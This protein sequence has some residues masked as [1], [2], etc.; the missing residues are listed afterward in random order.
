MLW[1][2]KLS[3]RLYILTL[4]ETKPYL[5][6][7]NLAI[8]VLALSLFAACNNDKKDKNTDTS[9]TT[10]TN[11]TTTADGGWTAEYKQTFMNQCVQGSTAQMGADKANTYCACMYDKLRAKYPV[12]DTLNNMNMEQMQNNMKGLASDCIK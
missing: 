4:A 10:T 6:M 11:T 7:K 5:V 3:V 8:A 9:T 2:I 1:R 12:A